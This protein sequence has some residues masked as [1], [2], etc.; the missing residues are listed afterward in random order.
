MA[1]LWIG[2]GHSE[3]GWQRTVCW[4]CKIPYQDP[5]LWMNRLAE[6]RLAQR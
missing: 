1:Q 2:I 6:E 3:E 4:L 5:Q